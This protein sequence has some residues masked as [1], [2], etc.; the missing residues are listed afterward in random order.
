MGK[1]EKPIDTSC[2]KFLVLMY[3]SCSEWYHILSCDAYTN[4]GYSV[5]PPLMD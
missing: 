2:I 5:S 3:N 4:P 1:K